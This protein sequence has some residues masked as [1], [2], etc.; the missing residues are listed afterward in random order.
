MGG[1]GSGGRFQKQV[2]SDVLYKL[3]KYGISISLM[4]K[5]AGVTYMVIYNVVNKKGGTKPYNRKKIEIFIEKIT[6]TFIWDEINELS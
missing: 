1:K 4:A 5:L 2:K 3:Y 6:N